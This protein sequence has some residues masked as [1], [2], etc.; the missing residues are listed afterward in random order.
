MLIFSIFSFC[1]C[2]WQVESVLQG[3]ENAKHEPS[4]SSKNHPIIFLALFIFVLVLGVAAFW[5][6]YRAYLREDTI[7][8]LINITVGFV[9]VVCLWKSLKDKVN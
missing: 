9:I 8:A 6:S 5:G 7:A 1:F 3:Y 2:V 4:K